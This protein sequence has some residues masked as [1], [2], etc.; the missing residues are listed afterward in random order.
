MKDILGKG[1]LAILRQ[2]ARR[3]V[4]VAFDFD[5]TLAPIV[6][7]PDVAAVPPRTAALLAKV[8]VRY[9]CVVISGRARADVLAKLADIP[10][11][12]VYGNHG[13]EPGRGLAAAKKLVA[14]WRE[15]LAS[16]LPI[17]PGL[18]VED[19]GPSLAIHYRRAR[20]RALIH[21][22]ILEAVAELADARVVEGKMV[23]NV[24]PANAPDK[25]V[26]LLRLCWRLRCDSALYVGD[27][28]T[29][30]DAFAVADEFA[31][32]GVRV[33]RSSRSRADYYLPRQAMI[34]PLL[35]T[36]ARLRQQ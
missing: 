20:S 30:E 36:L 31:L 28:D 34:D 35:N 16:F 18:V 5:G 24:L 26:A 13:M 25:G 15:E 22:L 23:V 33:G 11:Y 3:R 1:Q 21:R 9:P 29:D 17:V 19:K 32:F 10:L 27:D 14:R 2:L 4:L 7:D 12:A 8:A 6:R